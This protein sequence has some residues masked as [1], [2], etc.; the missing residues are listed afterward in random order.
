MLCRK[1]RRILWT[2][3]SLLL[4]LAS[5]INLS[6]A[7]DKVVPELLWSKVSTPDSLGILRFSPDGEWVVHGYGLYR[8][9]Q[10]WAMQSVPSH[11]LKGEAWFVGSHVLLV[12]EHDRAVLRHLPTLRPVK[13]LI[14]SP[15]RSR[16]QASSSREGDWLVLLNG[17]EVSLWEM[18]P[19]RRRAVWNPGYTSNPF[20][21]MSADGT[22][23]A[24]GGTYGTSYSG[25]GEVVVRHTAAGQ[26][27]ARFR[28][29]EPVFGAALSP[30]ASL[31]AI[32]HG[33][34]YSSGADARV[35]VYRLSDRRLLY[36]FNVSPRPMTTLSFS[37]DGR[38]LAGSVQA[39]M[40]ARQ[41]AL[42]RLSDGVQI[43]GESARSTTDEAFGV[44]FSPDGASLYVMTTSALKQI[45]VST[46]AVMRE[47]GARWVY[48]VGFVLDG[49]QV[50][51]V[52]R[53]PGESHLVL[54][55]SADGSEVRRLRLPLPEAPRVLTIS[56]DARYLAAAVGSDLLLFDLPGSGD[57]M[58]LWSAPLSGVDRMLFSPDASRLFV[59]SRSFEGATSLV[60]FD[61]QTGSSLQPMP[62]IQPVDCAV[63]PDGQYLALA[64]PYGFGIWRTDS[65]EQ[66]LTVPVPPDDDGLYETHRRTFFTADGRNAVFYDIRQASFGFHA[67]VW[68]CVLST[69]SVYHRV[70]SPVPA[71]YNAVGVSRDGGLLVLNQSVETLFW[72]LLSTSIS[73]PYPFGIVAMMDSSGP[74]VLGGDYLL[75][76]SELGSARLLRMPVSGLFNLMPTVVIDGWQGVL[77]EHLQYVLRDAST[78]QVVRR[79]TLMLQP[80][81]GTTTQ[82]TFRIPAELGR[83]YWLTIWGKPFLARTVLLPQPGVRQV[84]IRLV[85]GDTDGDNEVT[86]FDFGLMVR[87]FGAVLGEEEF[88]IDADLDGDGEV[89]L[90]DFAWL[91]AH[92][93]E[94]G[95]EPN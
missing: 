30:D 25:N 42:W 49:E 23:V 26:E 69:M 84:I 21:T 38:Y 2:L 78:G 4:L 45:D 86:L 17:S 62:G 80:V 76:A 44:Q 27:V 6:Y 41:W 43:A 15:Q 65:W 77:P 50:A 58:L 83:Y 34:D 10:E 60:V 37:P 8:V 53:T 29:G 92:F 33:V 13:V 61:T 64:E 16:M 19:P 46:G 88:N 93:G 57:A 5:R 40:E 55:R 59:I 32:S 73:Q 79:G 54:H 87:S 89:T 24:Y 74:V 71:A 68:V 36:T 47:V 67:E 28:L 48:P 20:V 95:D 22:R 56:Q 11:P 3:I 35:S 81:A 51:F 14:Q 82:G 91:V 1:T 66:L 7:Q 9:S 18:K 72:D 90:W 94:I 70:W 52:E 12:H 31:I 63:S 39:L 75:D 85:S